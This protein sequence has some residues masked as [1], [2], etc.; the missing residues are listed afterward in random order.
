MIGQGLVIDLYAVGLSLQNDSLSLNAK[1][2]ISYLVYNSL[3]IG[4]LF[5]GLLYHHGLAKVLCNMI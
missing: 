5:L 4:G 2:R 1:I 3:F